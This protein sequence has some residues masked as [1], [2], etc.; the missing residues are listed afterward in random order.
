MKILNSTEIKEK[1]NEYLPYLNDLQKIVG[2]DS[3]LN[4]IDVVDLHKNLVIEKDMNLTMKPWMIDAL[5]N[6]KLEKI[7]LIYDK[8]VNYNEELLKL[9]IGEFFTIFLFYEK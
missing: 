2:K 1:L 5:N 8:L 3:P 9:K 7:R 6:G 4:G